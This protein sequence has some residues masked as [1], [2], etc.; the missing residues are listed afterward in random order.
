LDEA[1]LFQGTDAA[2]VFERGLVRLRVGDV[3][4]AVSQ[5]PLLWLEEDPILAEL[6]ETWILVEQRSAGADG[7]LAQLI[8]RKDGLSHL[9]LSQ[10]RLL[11]CRR[12]LDLGG[13]DEAAEVAGLGL[14]L[15]N[16]NPRIAACRAEGWRRG[17]D[18]FQ[19]LEVTSRPW[20][21][22][23]SLPAMVAIRLRALVDLGRMDEA[24][25]LAEEMDVFDSDSA[26]SAWY[27][28]RAKGDAA[29]TLAASKKFA[30]LATPGASLDALKPEGV[31]W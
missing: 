28:A 26:A 21:Q 19:A 14:T 24:S 23:V 10:V 12:W 20:H 16:G 5:L 11:E 2:S 4:G 6:M 18:A 15:A 25:K 13:H 29:A 9:A 22:G 1:M 3:D 7:A 30:A 27:F 8:H 17:G 31:V